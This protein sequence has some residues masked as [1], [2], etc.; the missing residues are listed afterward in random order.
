MD[1]EPDDVVSTSPEE[2]ALKSQGRKAF[3]RAN[4]R[5]IFVLLSVWLVVSLG[6]LNTSRTCIITV[7]HWYR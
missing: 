5:L 3:W 7:R 4:K 1:S 6:P 2:D